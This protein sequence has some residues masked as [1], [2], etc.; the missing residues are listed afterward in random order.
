MISSEEFKTVL[1]QIEGYNLDIGAR[2]VN[3]GVNFYEASTKRPI[4]R[5]RASQAS[6]E[7]EVLWWSHREKWEQIGEFGGVVVPI[8]EVVDYIK[9]DTS[10]CFVL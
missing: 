9:N 3:R 5:I 6:G 1:K 7:V 10:G 4:A 2:K 8:N